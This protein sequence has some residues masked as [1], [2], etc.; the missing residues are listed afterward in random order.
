MKKSVKRTLALLL[1]ALLSL[2]VISCAKEETPSGNSGNGAPATTD[3]PA[4]TATSEA[5]PDATPS[6]GS[7]AGNQTGNPSAETPT[8]ASSGTGKGCGTTL[9]PAAACHLLIVAGTLFAAAKRKRK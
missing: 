1:A 2:T 8:P 5:W 4:E 9:L 6:G 3:A 7:Q